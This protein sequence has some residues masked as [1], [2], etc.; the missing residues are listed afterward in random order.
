MS[1]VITYPSVPN[2]LCA[3]FPTVV[4]ELSVTVDPL[5]ISTDLPAV[6][7]DVLP[8]VRVTRLSG[9]RHLGIDRA[10]TRFE[11]FVLTYDDAET[12]ANELDS[13]IE[14]NL[15]SFTDGKGRVMLT[16]SVAAPQFAAWDDQEVTRFLG[17]Y[18]LTVGVQQ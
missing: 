10:L 1:L 12:I 13:L 5:S 18:R 7:K 11:T 16:E 2:L 3:W 6:Y 4:G 8:F 17:T 14:F 9:P 15:C